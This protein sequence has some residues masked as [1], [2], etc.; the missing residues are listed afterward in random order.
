MEENR[1]DPR[2]IAALVLQGLKDEAIAMKLII[3]KPIVRTHLRKIFRSLRVDSRLS[4]A[5]RIF[6]TSRDIVD[7]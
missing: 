6:A 1:T 2:P 7:P 3:R 4:L 5:V